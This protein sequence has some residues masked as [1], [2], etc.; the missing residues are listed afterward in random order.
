MTKPDDILG[1]WNYGTSPQFA[2]GDETSYRKAMEF[3]DGPYV[4]EDWG[5][6]PFM[7]R[8]QTEDGIKKIS[9][10]VKNK[11][12]GKVLSL[13][14]SGNFVW[15]NVIGHRRVQNTSNKQWVR[16][17]TDTWLDEVVCT[18]DH[19]CAVVDDPLNPVVKFIPAGEAVGKF[20]VRVPK[21]GADNRLFNKEQVSVL[22]GNML[23][24]GTIN[25]GGQF[26]LKHGLK[27]FEYLRLNA[28]ILN[29]SS[30]YSEPAIEHEIYGRLTTTKES[31]TAIIPINGQT[32]YL[33][34]LFYPNGVKIVPEVILNRLD[35]L[36]LAFWYMDDGNISIQRRNQ[37]GRHDRPTV[38]LNTHCF[39]DQGLD[40]L[41]DWFRTRYDIEPYFRTVR[42]HGKIQKV[43]L[44][45]V[46]DSDKIYQI[47]S[48]YVPEQMQYKLPLHHR[49]KFDYSFDSVPLRF[50]AQPVR[51]VKDVSH[52]VD[53]NL[54]DLTVANDHNFV[55]NKT[56][57]HNCG[58]AWAG[59]FVKQ[60]RYVGI[61][62]SWSLHC[63]M[64]AD[65]RKYW[66]SADA[67]ML[68]H[69]LE[70]NWEWKKIL[71]NALASFQ[72]KLALV[73]FTP[74]CEETR[75]IGTTWGTIPDLS[76]RK[77]DL[78][79]YMKPFTFTE[80]SLRTATQYG[81]E[82]IFYITRRP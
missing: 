8:V 63:N 37:P 57:V 21:D 12:S 77:E 50:S 80:E 30:I 17:K 61:D 38:E 45:R 22:L 69:I 53:S 58:T 26:R 48:K 25:N 52:Y 68:R 60:G 5:C 70:H 44:F 73:L 76:F 16:L 11:Y 14:E 75:S 42:R 59:K 3:L 78:V 33:R 62:G 7:A 46:N 41:C 34:K 82:H 31:K 56:V 13:N 36:S 1:K 2:Y 43:M 29:A 39:P 23:G 72:K 6:L 35:D 27:Q 20:S 32:K 15:N 79:A 40:L 71:E 9:W 74:F 64:V 55:A 49:G 28:E 67:I 24:D 66:S 10:I 65:L 81:V 19:L 54:F 47:I 18:S 51:E 4:I